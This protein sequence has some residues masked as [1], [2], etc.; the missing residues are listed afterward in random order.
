MIKLGFPHLLMN[1]PN[2]NQPTI[3]DMMQQMQH[4]HIHANEH[5]QFQHFHPP[6][7][8]GVKLFKPH[9]GRQKYLALRQLLANLPDGENTR[10]TL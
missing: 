8:R 9:C 3:H 1:G 6:P 10:R 2:G 7:P 5:R 4:M